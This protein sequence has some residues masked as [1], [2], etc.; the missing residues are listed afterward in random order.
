[1]A[2]VFIYNRRFRGACVSRLRGSN[3]TST[4]IPDVDNAAVGKLLLCDRRI[5]QRVFSCFF[6]S[7]EK[8]LLTK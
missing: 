6:I 7:I 3:Q 1:M 4:L 2:P 8:G 5:P